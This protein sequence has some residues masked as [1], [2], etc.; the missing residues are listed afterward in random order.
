MAPTVKQHLAAIRSLFGWLATGGVLPLSPV[1]AVRGPR[2][3]VK[4]GKT[5]VLVPGKARQ[6]LDAI[7]VSTPVGLRD[8][9]FIGLMVYSFARIGSATIMKVED[10]YM[11]NRGL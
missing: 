6:L 5:P 11:Q 9:S 4:R 7:D 10:V 2:H 1:S 3:A 8:R